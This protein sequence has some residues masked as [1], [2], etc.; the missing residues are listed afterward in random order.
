LQLTNDG[1]GT[2]LLCISGLDSTPVSYTNYSLPI[3]AD[4]DYLVKLLVPGYYTYDGFVLSDDNG[5]HNKANRLPIAAANGAIR[6][7]I[8]EA[9]GPDELWLTLYLTPVDNP[10]R[11]NVDA[12]VNQA[13]KLKMA[14][15]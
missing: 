1:K 3:T 8:N 6:L 14:T 15:S 10:G 4:M 11:N 2:S 9:D 13:G 7:T 12:K 5:N